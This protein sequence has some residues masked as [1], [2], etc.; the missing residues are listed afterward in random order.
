VL[1]TSGSATG[2]VG[3]Q[4]VLPVT[5][6]ASGPGA[7]QTATLPTRT[8]GWRVTGFRGVNTSG[9]P[10][11]G[12]VKLQVATGTVDIT[13]AMIPGASNETFQNTTLVYTATLASAGVLNFVKAAGFTATQAWVW[14]EA[15]S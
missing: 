14:I 2:V 11:A 13:E 1:R 6:T 3:V 5:L 10:G 15:V 12:S 7:T 4:L 8:G 9:G